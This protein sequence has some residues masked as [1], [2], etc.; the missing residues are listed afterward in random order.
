MAERGFDSGF[1]TRR[2]PVRDRVIVLSGLAAAATLAWIYLLNMSWGMEH[3]D[4]GAVMVIMPRMTD[5]GVIDL[6][7]VL[8]M[9]A[10]MMAAMMLPSIVPMVLS[11]AFLSRQ[12]R[13]Q[14]LPYAHTSVFVL[15]YLAV[16]SGFSLLATLAQWGLLEAR[17][18]TPMMVSATSLLAGALLI[19]A[20]VFQLTPLKHACL[21]KCASPLGFLLNEWRDGSVGAWIMGF[22]HGAYCVGCCGALMAL[23][24]VFGVMNVLWVA[25]LSIYVM[26]EKMLPQARWLPFAEG[27]LLVGWGVEVATTG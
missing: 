1:A 14:R 3:M 7:L 19:V 23:L 21:S 22:R 18:V 27:L 17:L 16:W 2:L 11:F 6:L 12:R 13:A 9:W 10:I 24:F 26:L 5:W 15:G 4:A 20:G 25:A 8:A